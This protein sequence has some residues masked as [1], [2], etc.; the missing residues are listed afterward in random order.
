MWEQ[1][2]SCPCKVGPLPVLEVRRTSS[3]TD[4]QGT[5]DV[6]SI[7]LRVNAI[8]VPTEDAETVPAVS[9]YATMTRRCAHRQDDGGRR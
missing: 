3:Y 6:G 7:A 4:E 2:G 1:E 8:C 5:Q 9:P